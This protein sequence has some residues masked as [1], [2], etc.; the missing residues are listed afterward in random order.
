MAAM[1]N[2]QMDVA[3]AQT[4]EA[5]ELI[6]MERDRLYAEQIGRIQ[7]AT[8]I[9]ERA[10]RIIDDNLAN[11]PMLGAEGA[12]AVKRRLAERFKD[13]IL[14][15]VDPEVIR[16]TVTQY[17]GELTLA[18]AEGSNADGAN[19]DAGQVQHKRDAA[20]VS[21]ASSVKNG[22]AGVKP[23]SR[24]EETTKP[25]TPEE[26]KQMKQLGM[27][28]VKLYRAAKARQHVYAGR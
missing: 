27:T 25:P 4:P 7:Q 21:A 16:Q 5:K 8:M 23:A 12:E 11:Y 24:T 18:G 10:P 6:R 1:Q 13:N 17:F 2:L 20:A 26:A 9:R 14:A 3:T 22:R 28:D 19:A 15:Q